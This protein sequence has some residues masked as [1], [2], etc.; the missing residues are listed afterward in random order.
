MGYRYPPSIFSISFGTDF[1]NSIGARI[2]SIMESILVT[3]ATGFVGKA[4]C[5]R[6]LREGR[7]VRGTFLRAK[8]ADSLVAGV[9]PSG[10]DPITSVT[11]WGGALQGVDTV[12]H[13]A[14]RVHVINET[15][16]DPLGAFRSVNTEGTKN[17]ARQAAEAGIRRFV[18]LSTI[19]VN[20]DDSGSQP[21]TEWSNPQ[22]HN[23]YSVSKLEAEQLLQ[24]MASKS[25]ME[26]VILRAPLVYGPANPGNFLSLLRIVRKGYPLPL[27]LAVNKRSFLFIGNLVDALVVCAAHPAAA[28]KTFLV[29]DGEDIAVHEL[30]RRLAAALDVSARLF[31]VPV[32]ILKRIGSLLGRRNAVNGITNPLTVDISRIR[33][34]LGWTPPFTMEDGLRATA[35]WFNSLTVRS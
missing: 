29:S 5:D 8:G 9:E 35:Q 13:L 1:F 15:A 27:L 22:A 28:G 25:G 12:I 23:P 2:D 14:A 17:L 20:G 24:S 10:I 7:H 11:D 26:I 4:L 30:I 21:Y 33:R 31:P 32:P 19:G 3:G 16:S 6:L 34:E 18:F